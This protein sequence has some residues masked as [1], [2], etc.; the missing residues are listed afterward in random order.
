M[1]GFTALSQLSIY[2]WLGHHEM[3]GDPAL[4]LHWAVPAAQQA[5]GMGLTSLDGV[6]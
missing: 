5:V 2:F 4:V 3:L 1:F 6:S